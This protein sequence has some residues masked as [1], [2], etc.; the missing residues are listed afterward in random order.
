VRT[1]LLTA[2]SPNG[3]AISLWAF[4]AFRAGRCVSSTRKGPAKTANSHPILGIRLVRPGAAG[5]LAEGALHQS[6]KS[7]EEPN[8][9]AFIPGLDFAHPHTVGSYL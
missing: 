2:A 5:K 8:P 6:V 4:P 7:S 1:S 3:L 9:L